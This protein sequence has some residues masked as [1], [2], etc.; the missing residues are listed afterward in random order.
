MNLVQLCLFNYPQLH[1]KNI[2]ENIFI[3][4]RM[5]FFID[6]TKKINKQKNSLFYLH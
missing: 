1:K 3:L 5:G 2:S 6:M 4:T